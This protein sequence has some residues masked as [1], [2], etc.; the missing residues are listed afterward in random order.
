MRFTYDAYRELLVLLDNHGYKCV[1][2]HDWQSNQRCV[3]LRHDIDNDI[4]CALEFAKLEAELHAKSTFFVLVSSDLYNAFSRKS[5]EKLKQI[6]DYGHEIGL[7]FDETKYPEAM[8]DVEEV[9]LHILE[10]AAVLGKAIGRSVTCVSMHRPS[11]AIL[12]ANLAVPGM[13][14][15]YGRT[16]FHAFKYL[17]D[18]RR[19]WREPVEQIITSEE[20]ER[21]HILTHA[22][23]YREEEQD[24][25]MTL[26]TFMNHAND[27]RYWMLRDNIT[28]F[29]EILSESDVKGYAQD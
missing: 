18:S 8:G 21:L 23:W 15:S 24:M 2:Y 13:V 9:R 16:Y 3:I 12:D 11:Q 19:R 5:T 29:D 10:E 17:S 20:Y 22:F 28:N 25:R 27:E 6:L 26:E 4:A 14:N 7:H 1:D